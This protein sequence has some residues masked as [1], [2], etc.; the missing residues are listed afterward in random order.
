MCSGGAPWM[1]ATRV[2]VEAE[3][4][5]VR[6]LLGP[7]ELRIERFVAPG[8]EL[9]G[10]I[11]LEQEVRTPPPPSVDEGRLGDHL[12]AFA[13]GLRGARGGGR[14]VPRLAELDLDDRAALGPQALEMGA[15]VLR[16]LAGEELGL[17]V[18]DVRAGTLAARDLERKRREVGAL[19]VVVQVRR[20]E[21]EVAGEGAHGSGV[22]LRGRA[23]VTSPAGSPAEPLPSVDWGHLRGILRSC[24]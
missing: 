2:A 24:F 22:S 23:A 6:G 21:R 11:D 12:G 3:L 15:L 19:D 8:A 17:L 20:R 7:G 16:A 14:E 5:D 1:A 18:G 10:P 4:E 13:H 9:R